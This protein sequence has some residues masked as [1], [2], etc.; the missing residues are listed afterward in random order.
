MEYERLEINFV[1]VLNFLN[2][3]IPKKVDKE[4]FIKDIIFSIS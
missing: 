1:E 4:K 3:N 2:K